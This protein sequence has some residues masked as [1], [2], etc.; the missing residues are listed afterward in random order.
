[1]TR[2]FSC[3]APSAATR[4]WH[5]VARHV[6][7]PNGIIG[8]RSASPLAPD[9]VAAVGN[10]YLRS[11]ASLPSHCNHK[12]TMRSNIFVLDR[13]LSRS[14][15]G[16]G[17]LLKTAFNMNIYVCIHEYIYV[18]MYM[19]VSYICIYYIYTHLYIYII[20]EYKCLYV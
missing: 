18:C 3:G 1:M 9:F 2:G 4:G 16:K 10:K 7:N 15:T 13:I 20:H 11:S 8:A 12:Y 6:H 19:Y 5:Q 17:V 14:G